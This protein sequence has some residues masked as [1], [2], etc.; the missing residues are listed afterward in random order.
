MK[1]IRFIL[2]VACFSTVCI[3]LSPIL[4]LGYFLDLITDGAYFKYIDDAWNTIVLEK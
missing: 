1:Y 2:F 3:A 4:F